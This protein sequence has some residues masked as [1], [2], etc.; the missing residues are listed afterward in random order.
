MRLCYLLDGLEIDINKSLLSKVTPNFLH[1]GKESISICN[2]LEIVAKLSKWETVAKSSK[3]EAVN[4]LPYGQWKI[5]KQ[6]VKWK[7]ALIVCP[8]VNKL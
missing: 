3:C 6:K 8:C 5:L 1:V 7:A 4:L 2:I